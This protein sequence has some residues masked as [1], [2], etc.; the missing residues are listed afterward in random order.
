MCA[1]QWKLVRAATTNLE[2]KMGNWNKLE[3]FDP[4]PTNTLGNQGVM[5]TSA[6]VTHD[7]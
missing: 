7:L 4:E 3:Q 1:S 2:L 6:E 5:I